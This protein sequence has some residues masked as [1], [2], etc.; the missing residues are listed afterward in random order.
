MIKSHSFHLSTAMTDICHPE[1]APVALNA[2]SLHRGQELQLSGLD[3]QTS[4]IDVLVKTESSLLTSSSALNEM[5][6]SSGVGLVSSKCLSCFCKRPIPENFI[7]G[8]DLGTEIHPKCGGCKCGKCPIRGHT[9]SFREEQELNLINSNLEYDHKNQRWMT[10]YP[11]ILDP[12]LLPDN[13]CS[14]LATLRNT[15]KKLL[16]ETDWAVKYTEQIQDMEKRGVARK[17][18]DAEMTAWQGPVFYLSHL[19]V[20]SP[21]SLSTPVRI[22]FN[23]SQLYKGVSLNSFLAKGPDSFKTNLLGML[24]RFRERPVV[25]VGDIRKM[26]NSVFLDEVAQ[27]THRFLWRDLNVDNPPDVWCITRVNM[28]DKPAGAIAIEAKDRTADLFRHIHPKASDFIKGSSYVDDLVDSFDNLDI[29]QEVAKGV[30]EILVKGGFQVKGWNY[31]GRDIQVASSEVQKVLGVSWVASDDILLVQ[32]QL[33]FS[34]KRRNIRTGPNLL[35][36]EVPDMLPQTLTRR[37]V[38]QQVMSIFDPYGLLAPFVLIAKILLRETWTQQLQWDDLLTPT[39]YSKWT[40]FF[41]QLLE[42]NKFRFERC[43]TPRGAVGKPILILFSDGS[44]VAYGCAAYIRWTLSD[45]TYFCRLL[46]AKCRISPLRRISI[47]QMELNGAVLSKRCRKVIETECRFTF[48]RIFQ[49]VD[50]ETV[51]AQIHNLSTR[52]HV[53]E[54]VRIGEIQAATGGDVSCWGW[55]SG[56]KN[57][58][59]LVTRGRPIS[60]IGPG[61][62]WIDGPEFLYKPLE[63]WGVRFKPSPS[64]SLP[65]E[66]RISINACLSVESVLDLGLS[67]LRCSSL[68]VVLWS[69]A[70]ILSIF[71]SRSF[72]GG[73]RSNVTLALLKNVEQILITIVQADWTPVT[74]KNQFRSLQPIHLA[75]LWVVGTRISHQSPLTPENKPQIL[76]PYSH[77]YTKLVMVDAHCKGGHRGR[78][79]TVARF[80]TRFWTS[81]ATKLSKSVCDN[82]QL[83]RLRNAKQL[84]QIM[85][86]MPSSRLM[87]SPPFTSVMLDLFGPYHVRGEVQKRITC[88]A[89][90]VIFTDLCSRGVHIE[91]VFGY[92]TKSFL[93]ALSRFAAIRGWPSVIYSDPGSQL[94]GAS[95]D[96][97]SIWKSIDQDVLK[98]VGVDHGLVWKFGPTDSPWYQ[99]AVEA[100]VKSAKR[101]INLSVKGHRLSVSEIMTVFTQVA[102]LLNERP[103]GVMPGEDS[104]IS[105][106][107]PNS[108]LLGRSCSVNPGGY[109]ANPS[110]KSRLTLVQSLVD[111]FWSH[112][113]KLYAP[114]LVKQSKWFQEK[115][116][117]KV[118]DVVVVSD[119]GM[120][121]GRYRLGKVTKVIPSADGRVRRVFIMFKRYK[122]GE[123]VFEYKGSSNIEVERSIQHL[124]LL[125]P[126]EGDGNLACVL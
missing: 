48:E 57:I 80:R 73:K 46:M 125:V 101:A 32:T 119:S 49:L 23:S 79:A 7:M 69:F 83:C 41:V 100:L 2:N 103:L 76:L 66:K 85:G 84:S 77:P 47:P 19:A 105:I 63:E 72:N 40:E 92:D 62:Q 78:D 88:K 1:F 126:A 65:G 110:L 6:S 81:H 109:D 93:L 12:K 4:Q 123:K 21:K 70:R 124:A 120:Q 18:S 102:D 94:V 42:A 87:P 98:Q 38:L 89:W 118:G 90:G 95:N 64:D 59:D 97:V 11:W 104:D 16:N 99:G 122:V 121:R 31:G 106:L 82:C 52:F 111:Q 37:I 22:V 116:D 117:L 10:S 36:N 55:I 14:A 68:K 107:T 108:L 39:M 8:E 113:S 45:G 20:E 91:V 9:Y 30:D 112:W 3:I 96:L 75:G 15:E 5:H 26:Y 114:T 43:V 13:F 71:K 24:L 28:G 56:D 54:G 35:P 115:R 74:I 53:Y 58:A 60:D 86:Q 33:N 29:A 44:Q 51:L 25:L 17:L 50:S 27:H 61:S 67:C 34:P